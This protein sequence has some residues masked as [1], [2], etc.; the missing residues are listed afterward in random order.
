MRLLSKIER[1]CGSIAFFILIIN[2]D[3]TNIYE[4]ENVVR[5]TTLI[6]FRE[7]MHIILF[8][9]SKTYFFYICENKIDGSRQG[10]I[11][12]DAQGARATPLNFQSGNF[13]TQ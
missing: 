2:Y 5:I 11:N 6:Y 12:G 13:P 4:I 9:I 3:V 1:R 8:A 7:K 10:R